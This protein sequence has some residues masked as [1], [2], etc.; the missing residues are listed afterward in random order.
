MVRGQVDRVEDCFF[1]FF[2]NRV[3]AIV[4]VFRISILFPWKFVNASSHLVL[5]ALMS[6]LVLLRTMF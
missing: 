1:F 2:L 5:L 4:I 3:M 6:F